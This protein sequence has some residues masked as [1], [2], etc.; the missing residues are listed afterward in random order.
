MQI[1]PRIKK[2][3][4]DIDQEIDDQVARGDDQHDPLNH[5]EIAPPEG[6]DP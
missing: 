1:N 6:I 2:R 3:V 4:Q 5:R